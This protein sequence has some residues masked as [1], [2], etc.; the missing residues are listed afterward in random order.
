MVLFSTFTG[1]LASFIA[2]SGHGS[3]WSPCSC[4]QAVE[5]LVASEPGGRASEGGIPKSIGGGSSSSLFVHSWSLVSSRDVIRG[6]TWLRKLLLDFSRWAGGTH[7]KRRWHSSLVALVISIWLVTPYLTS[8]GAMPVRRCRLF[9][10][11]GFK[12]PVIEWLFSVCSM[13][14]CSFLPYQL[15]PVEFAISAG[16][17]LIGRS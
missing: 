16:S 2:P 6:W 8:A 17:I 7:Q 5:R 14:F 13:P 11:V 4:S 15:S 9:M 10:L 12:Q 3:F 1:C